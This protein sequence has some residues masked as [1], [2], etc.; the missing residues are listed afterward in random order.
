[1]DK[2]DKPKI[3]E[4][5]KSFIRLFKMV[6]E[7]DRNTIIAS[8]I[9]MTILTLLP[10]GINYINASVIDQIVLLTSNLPVEIDTSN[11]L[12]TA[13][14]VF[15][16]IRIVLSLSES[17]FWI[18]FWYFNKKLY[19][20]ITRYFSFKFIEKTAS[21]DISLFENQETSN[22]IQ[23]A[24]EAGEWRP[25]EITNRFIWNI[26]NIVSIIVS[27]GIVL[28][29]SPLAFLVVVISTLPS[30]IANAK[31]GVGSWG[32][33]NANATDRKRYWWTMDYLQ[34][35]DSLKEIRI[36][37]TK[38]YLIDLVKGI[39]NGFF[40]KERKNEERR[41]IIQSIFGNLS[42]IGI[43][44]FWVILILSV[45][46]G[47]ITIGL[48]TFYI[49]SMGNFSR[50]LSGLITNLTQQYEDSLYVIDV[51]KFYDLKNNIVSGEYKLEKSIEPP[52]IEF[53]D[54][55]FKYPGTDKYIL[56][57]FNLIINPK[58]KIAVV[59]VNGAGKSTMIKLLC[60]FYDPT[61]G[62]ILIGGKSLKDIDN[63]TWYEKIG[64]LFQDFVQ[65]GQLDLRTNV[66]IGDIEKIGNENEVLNSIK[67]AS[68]DNLLKEYKSGL[69]QILSMSFEGG[70]DPSGGQW[71]RIALSRAFFRNAPI[72]ILDEPTSAIDAKGES[73][74][75]D[76]LFNESKDKTIIIISHR[77]STV[78]RA[79]RI[80]VIDNGNIIE[81]G[82]H[83]EL[84][85]KNGKYAESFS[86]QAKGYL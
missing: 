59:G 16:G 27:V 26:E 14:I 51:L 67:K 63:E 62:D 48:L 30:L 64:V 73:E 23:K 75:F 7:A 3:K 24:S 35:V 32:I 20:T 52:L 56:K 70:I 42:E 54:V 33:W 31:L 36:F 82:T 84:L 11:P 79:D 86:L 1:M 6:L 18:I 77:F 85:S 15:I 72:L 5:L 69:D 53:K 37:R 39:Y 41:S 81:E 29:F 71:Q 4:S 25:R 2:K 17:T 45:L 55:T 13:L 83:N 10:F 38:N 12:I 43:L 78:R 74:I 68:A 60:R 47:D 22:I 66:E 44:F 9:V 8:V 19:F 50:S 40:E 65:Y 80:I 49:A 28:S 76:T 58:D 57:N 46:K 34:K 61:E 21:L